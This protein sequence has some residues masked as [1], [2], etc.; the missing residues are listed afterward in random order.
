MGEYLAR[1]LGSDV[2]VVGFLAFEGERGQLF[3]DTAF[4]T[5]IPAPP[6]G[7]LDWLLGQLGEPVLFLDLRSLPADHWLRDR[8][9]ARPGYSDMNASW[10]DVYDAVVFT[11]HMFPNRRIRPLG[12][13]T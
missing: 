12:G 4:T 11:R 3:P 9:I 13:G 5:T 1:D 6:T 2:Y 8:L 7:S 10:P